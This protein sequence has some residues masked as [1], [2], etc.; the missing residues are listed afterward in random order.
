MGPKDQVDDSDNPVFDSSLHLFTNIKK[1]LQRCTSF[2]TSK[3]LFDLHNAI[4]NVFR[5]YLKELKRSGPKFAHGD[6]KIAILEDQ[7]VHLAHMINTCEYC[8]Q[9]VPSVHRNVK[10]KIDEEY[11]EKIDLESSADLFRE[12]INQCITGIL[13]SLECKMDTQYVQMLK[14][15]W[16]NFDQVHDTLPYMKNIIQTIK[17]TVTNM[18]LNMNP[19][20]FT[21]F[22]NK[23]GDSIPKIYITNI[24]KIRKSSQLSSQ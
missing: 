22:L 24:Y 23:I 18:R 21:Y 14:Q 9:T 1:S 16:V 3:T 19:T 13:H 10:D 8:I 20:Y 17:T 7:E 2:S 15:N 4:K 5:A 6:E 11:K 12:V